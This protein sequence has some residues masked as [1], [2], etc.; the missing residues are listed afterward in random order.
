MK[1]RDTS[2]A[3]AE[4]CWPDGPG[5]ESR[6]GK[7]TFPYSTASK[8]VLGTTQAHIQWVP[9][10]LSPGAKRPGCEADHVFHGA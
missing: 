1:N 5:F 2:L 7:E 3:T 6:Q 4:N 9:G 10:A 8:P